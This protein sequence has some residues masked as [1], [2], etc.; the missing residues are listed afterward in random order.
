MDDGRG[1]G[2]WA[3]MPAWAAPHPCNAHVTALIHYP[4][5]MLVPSP[6]RARET[7]S[8]TLTH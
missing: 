6:L 7:I 8:V 3:A 1:A 2:G 4:Q 5:D